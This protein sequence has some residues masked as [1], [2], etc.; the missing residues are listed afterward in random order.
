[1]DTK[2]IANSGMISLRTEMRDS[3]PRYYPIMTIGEAES[4]SLTKPEELRDIELLE[5]LINESDTNQSSK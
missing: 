4:A 5:K 3:Q 1:M 2:D